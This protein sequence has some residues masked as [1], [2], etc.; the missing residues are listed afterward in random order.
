V[1][2][3]RPSTIELGGLEGEGFES[4]LLKMGIEGWGLYNLLVSKNSRNSYGHFYLRP[5][6]SVPSRQ[7]RRQGPGGL[8][9]PGVPGMVGRAPGRAFV[10]PKDGRPMG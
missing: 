4:G 6:C 10:F 9:V 8:V 2:Q 3:R 5:S 1:L 7:G